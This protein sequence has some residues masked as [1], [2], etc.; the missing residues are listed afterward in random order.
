MNG[1][2]VSKVLEYLGMEVDE[3]IE[4]IIS[5]LE[6]EGTISENVLAERLGLKINQTRKLLYK[7]HDL[8]FAEYSKKKDE[9]KKWWYIYFWSLNKVKLNDTYKRRKNEELAEMQD[10]LRTEQ[11]YSFECTKCGVKF[12]YEDALSHD[13][14]CDSCSSPLSEVKNSAL[15]SQIENSISKL[16]KEFGDS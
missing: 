16:K 8:G 3:Q 1:M 4:K 7:L 12:K 10:Q 14:S 6:K 15:I 13:F 11:K 2:P 5:F 9:E